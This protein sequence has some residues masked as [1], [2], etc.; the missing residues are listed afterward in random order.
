MQT[1][2]FWYCGNISEC[3]SYFMWN[4]GL[5]LLPHSS[6]FSHF[7]LS[8]LFPSCLILTLISTVIPWSGGLFS[9]HRA[10]ASPPS[11]HFTARAMQWVRSQILQCQLLSSVTHLWLSMNSYLLLGSV[12]SV[13]GKTFRV[14]HSTPLFSSA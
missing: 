7:V 11:G 9:C 4:Q 1:S 13:S 5:S 12:G 3:G 2:S 10:S 14:P 6:G 8:I